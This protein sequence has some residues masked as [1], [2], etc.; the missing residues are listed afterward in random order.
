MAARVAGGF[1]RR[2]VVDIERFIAFDTN[3][4]E[5]VPG[6]LLTDSVLGMF[7]QQVHHE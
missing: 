3:E 6:P 4:I 5:L 1:F 7:D 2:V